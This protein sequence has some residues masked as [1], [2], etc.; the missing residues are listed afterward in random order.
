[1]LTT[2]TEIEYVP[3]ETTT[4]TKKAVKIVLTL[5]ANGRWSMKGLVQKCFLGAKRCKVWIKLKTRETKKKKTDG[6]DIHEVPKAIISYY[7]ENGII[8]GKERQCKTRFQLNE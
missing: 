3:G 4:T 2:H 8:E 1:M 6:C 7:G 5:L